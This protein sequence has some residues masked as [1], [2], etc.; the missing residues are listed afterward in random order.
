MHKTNPM[1]T[2]ISLRFELR[3]LHMQWAIYT[4]SDTIEASHLVKWWL[5]KYKTNEKVNE[6]L[7]ADRM[8]ICPKQKPM[9]HSRLPCLQWRMSLTF[10]ALVFVCCCLL[11]VVCCLLFVVCCWL[12]V[13][14]FVV[15]CL[16]VC[17]FV[18]CCLLSVVC[19]L[20][21]VVC[22]LLFVVCCLLFVVC[23]LLLV[24]WLI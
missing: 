14:L 18:V 13:W 21:F 6:K 8:Q 9:N 22:C 23:C 12:F 19:C 4:P 11:F 15:C 16:F 24:V 7:L 17:L 3:L 5:K 10:H 1:K 20:L 2:L